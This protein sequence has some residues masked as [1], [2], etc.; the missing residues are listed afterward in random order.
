[1]AGRASWNVGTLLWAVAFAALALAALLAPADAGGVVGLVA[2]GHG[3]WLTAF[4]V[5]PTVRRSAADGRAQA[6][7][8]VVLVVLGSCEA[9]GL[10]RAL[11]ER[12]WDQGLWFG[13]ALSFAAAGVLG[14]MRRGPSDGVLA[15]QLFFHGLMLVPALAALADRLL[16]TGG[17]GPLAPRLVVI[18]GVAVPV[19]FATLLLILAHD[20]HRPPEARDLAWAALLAHQ[21]AY[22]VILIRW[23][24][25]GL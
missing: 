15:C 5:E 20:L 8:A 21:A 18:V 14:T 7:V 12:E 19:L 25:H 2:V 23:A 24:G 16:A 3:L 9:L 10:A 13:L 4:Y 22:V 17:A 6:L 1:M 11:A